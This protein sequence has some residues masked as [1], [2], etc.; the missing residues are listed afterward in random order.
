MAP[1]PTSQANS[2]HHFSPSP[3][4]LPVPLS[5][6]QGSPSSFGTSTDSTGSYSITIDHD[7]PET[8]LPTTSAPSDDSQ[9]PSASQASNNSAYPA[10]S[11]SGQAT[12]KTQDVA[13]LRQQLQEWLDIRKWWQ[14]FLAIVTLVLGVVGLVYS[15]YRSYNL[16]RWTAAKDFYQQ[17]QNAKVSPRSGLSF[18][19]S[20]TRSR[21]GSE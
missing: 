13:T 12:I 11:T 15:A 14:G 8:A 5:S 20:L 4:N 6:L 19:K 21:S 3:T 18:L 1:A 16:A 17:C 9:Y 2:P 7:R 10:F